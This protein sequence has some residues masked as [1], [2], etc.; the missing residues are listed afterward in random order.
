MSATYSVSFDAINELE[1][2]IRHLYHLL[3]TLC[4]E[5]FGATDHERC[6][7]L[8]WI[9]RDRA[10]KIKDDAH[11]ACCQGDIEHAPRMVGG[12]RNG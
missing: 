9:A 11:A 3:D 6:D 2:D 8:L 10:A 7:A 12:E 5:Q 1:S 4:D